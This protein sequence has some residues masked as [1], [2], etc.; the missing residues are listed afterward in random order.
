MSSAPSPA[1]VP[2]KPPLPGHIR[3]RQTSTDS[4]ASN[5]REERAELGLLASLEHRRNHTKTASGDVW[6]SA[7][8]GERPPLYSVPSQVSAAIE[9]S[10]TH[11][12]NNSTG[13][14]GESSGGT[15]NWRGLARRVVELNRTSNTNTGSTASSSAS[16]D[17]GSH[18]SSHNSNNLKRHP[19]GAS[20]AHILLGMIQEDD[21]EGADERNQNDN[22]NP[23]AEGLF[24]NVG[25]DAHPEQGDSLFSVE[26]TSTDRLFAGASVVND[27]FETDEDTPSETSGGAQDDANNYSNDNNNGDET[28]PL[29]SS[30]RNDGYGSNNVS[31][32]INGS[33]NNRRL[34]RKKKRSHWQKMRECISRFLD[35]RRL[36]ILLCRT[37]ESA[38]FFM[39]SVPIFFFSW[40][41][42]Q[43]LDN[44]RFDYLPGNAS[45]AWWVNLLGRLCLTLELARLAQWIVM[46][47]I[48]L[49]TRT[50][51]RL[52]GPLVT[53]Y[54]I[55]GRGWPFVVTMWSVIKYV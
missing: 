12:G 7:V 16:N 30:D 1:A 9:A 26:G 42:Y 29:T 28:L 4:A 11:S 37:A 22:N 35:P 14:G 25:G 54:A 47:N 31:G 18:S 38:W 17:S 13:G 34:S 45:L 50:A 6:Y 3:T 15:R 33:G 51:A 2:G 46:D 39:A 10:S 8:E 21:N 49:G 43:Y 53:L 52:L 41:L 44:P 32:N 48:V 20:R 5:A 55:Q 19:R 36:L 24:E 40:V 23:P 27:L